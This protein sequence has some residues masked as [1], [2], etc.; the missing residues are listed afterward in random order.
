ME[1]G[2]GDLSLIFFPNFI[3]TLWGE[4]PGSDFVSMHREDVT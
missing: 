2:L 4:N 3:S 1:W